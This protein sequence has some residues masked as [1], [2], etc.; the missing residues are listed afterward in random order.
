M[1]DIFRF[2]HF[3]VNQTGCAMKVNTD[4]VL[5][6]AIAG[7][8]QPRS[9][10]D[11]GTGTGVIALMLAQRFTDARI[12]AIEIDTIAAYTA[13]ENF[14]QSHYAERLQLYSGDYL[15][16]L[17][18]PLDKKY[19][20]IVSNPPFY[21]QSL[22]SPQAQKSVAKH[23]DEQ[24]FST[25]IQQVA[26]HL[27][28]DGECW[29]ILPLRTAALIKELAADK[30]LYLQQSLLISSFS[31]GVPHREIL[32]FGSGKV[33]VITEQLNIY[34]EQKVYAPL[35]VSLLKDFLTIF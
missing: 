24:F 11:I 25:L 9:V 34:S 20:L 17:N 22:K 2:K 26:Q 32:A 28:A 19:D 4:G 8:G 21:I 33:E 12:D 23:A 1:S 10:L 35:Y 13:R 27:S 3:A 15:D 6:G 30:Q 5:L 7:K 31:D 14:N 29:L 16:Y 18:L